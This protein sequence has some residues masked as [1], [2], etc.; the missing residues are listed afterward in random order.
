MAGGSIT[1][2]VVNYYTNYELVPDGESNHI[3]IKRKIDH[4]P[5]S[6]LDGLGDETGTPYEEF[7]NKCSEALSDNS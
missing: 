4:A 7:N 5:I 3:K 1:E 2:Q 6:P